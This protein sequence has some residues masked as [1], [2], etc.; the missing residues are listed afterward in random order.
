MRY[1][2]ALPHKHLGFPDVAHFH[3]FRHISRG[4]SPNREISQGLEFA[5]Q[6]TAKQEDPEVTRTHT[7]WSK[8]LNLTTWRSTPRVVKNRRKLKTRIPT[9]VTFVSITL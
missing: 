4:I 9:L 5:Y 7:S 1:H 3:S 8:V 6:A 2:V